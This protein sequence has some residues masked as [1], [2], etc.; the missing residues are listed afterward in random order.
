MNGDRGQ[1]QGEDDCVTMAAGLPD[2]QHTVQ[3]ALLIG[4]AGKDKLLQ[5][6]NRLKHDWS[7]AAKT[8]ST[9]KLFYTFE[10]EDGAL[11][12]DIDD[13]MRQRVKPR[14]TDVVGA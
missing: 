1:L 9:E 3:R 4:F 6:R 5:C 8:A 13:A 2:D 10:D 7:I 14:S 12:F 11:R